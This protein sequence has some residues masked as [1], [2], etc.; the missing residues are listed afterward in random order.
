MVLSS[1]ATA[2]FVLSSTG[3][4]STLSMTSTSSLSQTSITLNFDTAVT[5]ILPAG[6][7]FTITISN[8]QNYFSFK[9]V[10]IQMVAFTSDN[11]AV[12]QSDAAAVTLVNTITDSSLV[13]GTSNT[14][15]LNGQTII[16]NF[17]V[18]SPVD[19]TATD[20]IS[21]EILTTNNI[22]TQ[23]AFTSSVSCAVGGTGTNCTKGVGNS[24]LL[25]VTTGTV[26]T[27]NV[28]ATVAVSSIVLTRAQ[29]TPGN[30][31]VN[32]F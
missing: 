27:A 28:A 7:V 13:V 3:V 26:F 23:L 31:I 8:I 32:T 6:T 15:T 18:T 24:N 22:N 9:P 10:N 16:Y 17:T 14:A 4:N 25:T 19:L 30:I 20:L 29:D 1:G 5:T 12:E 2:N 21:F 11:F